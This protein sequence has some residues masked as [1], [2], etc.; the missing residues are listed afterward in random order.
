MSSS[1][2]LA[3]GVV[4]STA[5]LALLA[6]QPKAEDARLMQGEDPYFKQAQG[7]LQRILTQ[8]RNTNQAKNVILVVG[9]GMGLSTVTAARI[10][11][12]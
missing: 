2:K 8:P 7:Q 3:L 9:D 10:F 11:E 5:A 4:L 6:G 1:T 12:G